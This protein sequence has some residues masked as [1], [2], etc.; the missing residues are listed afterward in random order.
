MF[1][2]IYTYNND[3]LQSD[4]LLNLEQVEKDFSLELQNKVAGKKRTN[5]IIASNKSEDTIVSLKMIRET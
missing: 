4:T 2:A 3:F 5:F 1:D